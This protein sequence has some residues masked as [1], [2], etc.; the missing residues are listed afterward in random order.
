MVAPWVR[1]SIKPSPLFLGQLAQ[2]VERLHGALLNRGQAGHGNQPAEFLQR[3][4]VFDLEKQILPAGIV[5]DYRL[6][7]GLLDINIL[8]PPEHEATIRQRWKQG[9]P[10]RDSHEEGP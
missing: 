8:V 1:G 6:L 9:E 4:L 5:N 3:P 10:P 7:R 2:F